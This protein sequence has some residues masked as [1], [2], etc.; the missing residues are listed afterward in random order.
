MVCTAAVVDWED[1]LGKPANARIVLD[2]DHARFE[3]LVAAALGAG[4]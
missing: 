1:R 4:A 2:V 3:A